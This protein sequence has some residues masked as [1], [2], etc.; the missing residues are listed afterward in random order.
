M[1]NRFMQCRTTSFA[2][3][4][5]A[6]GMILSS[7][8][9]SYAA[10]GSEILRDPSTPPSTRLKKKCPKGK[11]YRGKLKKC[12]VKTSEALTDSELYTAGYRLAKSK[13]YKEAL[14]TFSLIKNKER[15][16]VLT[17]IGFSTRKLGKVDEGINFYMKALALDPNYVEAREYLGEG[18]LQK[19][20][21]EKAKEQLAEIE[22][23]CGKKCEEYEDLAKAIRK[24]IK[25][26]A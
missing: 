1:S 26:H 24:H 11:V 20:E 2:A 7:A 3:V 6:L 8:G 23:R 15:A 4:V 9:L 17:F 21:P 25:Q 16:Q 5:I 13:Q 10:G 19:G 18:F 12:V 14:D 22:K